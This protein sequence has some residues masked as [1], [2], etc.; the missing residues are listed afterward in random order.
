MLTRIELWRKPFETVLDEIK[1]DPFNWDGNDCVTGL[2]GKVVMTLTGEDVVA[3]HRGKYKDAKGAIAYLKRLGH[4]DLADMVAT[5]LPEIPVSMAQIGD[6]VAIPGDKQFKYA[7][8]VVN[9]ERVFVMTEAGVGTVDLLD[10]KRA[11]KVG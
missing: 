4:D 7:L 10:A 3:E 9:G 6:I 2:I 5:V 8:G 1:A 11:F